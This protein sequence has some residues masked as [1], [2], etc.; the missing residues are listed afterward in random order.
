MQITLIYI[1]I[2][3]ITYLCD[4]YSSGTSNLSSLS[5]LWGKGGSSFASQVGNEH[6]NIG[7]RLEEEKYRRQVCTELLSLLI[8]KVKSLFE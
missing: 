1:Y 8:L 4:C 5:E 6:T 7:L 2:R 3:V